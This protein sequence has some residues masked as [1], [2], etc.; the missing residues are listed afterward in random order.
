MAPKANL[1]FYDQ[2]AKSAGF[3][4][5][6]VSKEVFAIDTM[7]GEL[8]QHGSYKI[9]AGGT[10][11][12]LDK[13]GFPKEGTPLG[14]NSVITD[15]HVGLHDRTLGNW[16]E[17]FN[18]YGG[19]T[20]YG[21]IILA[22][23]V[24]NFQLWAKSQ[25]CLDEVKGVV[26]G[27]LFAYIDGYILSVSLQTN[28]AAATVSNGQGKIVW[29]DGDFYVGMIKSSKMHGQGTMNYTSGSKYVGPFVEANK[30]GQGTYTD[31]NGTVK[32]GVW[33]NG[34]H[35]QPI[36]RHAKVHPSHSK[37]RRNKITSESWHVPRMA[38]L[39]RCAI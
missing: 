10:R 36:P 37:Q 24:E 4:A 17:G 27:R 12:E 8:E 13:L 38:P 39:E 14:P 23:T 33:E 5:S 30:H 21:A 11:A 6:K 29:G 2:T 16:R 34:K 15:N 32:K 35:R 28:Q 31:A 7:R 25:P 20:K 22:G 18:R 26:Q 3:I 1:S 19:L 9:G